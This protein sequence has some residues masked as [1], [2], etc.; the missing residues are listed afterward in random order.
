MMYSE[1]SPVAGSRT[2]AT[3]KEMSLEFLDDFDSILGVFM[4][5]YSDSSV[6]ASYIGW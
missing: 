6:L 3:N 4:V 5:G 2:E 1:V